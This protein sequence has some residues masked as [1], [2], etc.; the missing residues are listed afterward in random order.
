VPPSPSLSYRPDIDA[1]R[2]LAV[3]AVILYHLQFSFIKGGFVGVDVFLVISGFLITKLC[4]A[5]TTLTPKT[6]VLFILRRLKRLLP[7]M[8]TVVFLSSVAAYFILLPDVMASFGKS[9][10]AAL[11]FVSNLVFAREAGYFDIGHDMKPLLH[12][13]SL[14]VEM[15]FYLFFPLF[16]FTARKI[17]PLIPALAVLA[18]LSFAGALVLGHGNP[19]LNFYL[20][21][22]RLWEFAFGA[23]AALPGGPK[24][25]VKWQGAASLS[26][27][28]VIAV[29]FAA[30]DSEIPHPG[31]WAVF[32]CLAAYLVMA[33]PDF[34]ARLFERFP[35]TGGALA[36]TGRISYHLY[37]FHYPLIVFALYI[38]QRDMSVTEKLG[39]MAATILL[40][41]LPFSFIERPIRASKDPV[42]LRKIAVA[43]LVSV[44]LLCAFGGYAYT[45]K[46][47]KDRFPGLPP[48]LLDGVYAHLHPRHA[49]CMDLDPSG[50]PGNLCRIGAAG[51][52]PGIILWGDSHALMYMP[53]LE[54]IAQEEGRSVL[55]AGI[56]NCPPVPG[57]V[58]HE[59]S[60]RRNH[61]DCPV[62][63]EAVMAHI[64]AMP[65]LKTVILGSFWLN[66]LYADPAAETP[67][68]GPDYI[69]EEG[70][71]K[72]QEGR[73]QQ[74]MAALTGTIERL[75]K[76]GKRVV[77]IGPIPTYGFD[78][79]QR[80]GRNLL[81]GVQTPVGMPLAGYEKKYPYALGQF[82][83]LKSLDAASAVCR[84][85]YCYAAEGSQLYYADKSHME[86][87]TTM[88]LKSRFLKALN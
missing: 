43:G 85:G 18:G 36:Y 65:A 68:P 87:S 34:N 4:L 6:Y 64:L 81:Y 75:K 2:A 72:T 31:P 9:A 56:S 15:Q 40:A 88:R 25:P 30:F 22:T 60:S 71:A 13:W 29:S 44:V 42:F 7:G 1:L 28:L 59:P 20:M 84:D 70:A 73:A 14:G 19:D 37:L 21:P 48:G 66:R 63:N 45:A 24:I 17:M 57:L 41:V 86:R 3:L 80:L 33:A 27:L 38:L 53:V 62:H 32:T 51:V 76:A 11:L 52:E 78:V 49:A 58:Y 77:V 79:P 83:R 23:L 26:G 10:A 82:R 67:V 74:F 50:Y 12:T 47:I 39:L 55:V 54:E 35:R 61:R 16:V 46:G 5:E 8:V 69:L